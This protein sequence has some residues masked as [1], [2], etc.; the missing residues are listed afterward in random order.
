M[1]Q[2]IT[3]QRWEWRKVKK[4]KKRGGGVGGG[5]GGHRRPPVGSRGNDLGG[6]HGAKPVKLTAFCPNLRYE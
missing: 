2:L 3:K 4:R 5:G 6:G 1:R